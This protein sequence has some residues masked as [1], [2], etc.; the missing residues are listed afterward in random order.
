MLY[1]LVKN[2]RSYRGYDHSRKV[3]KEEL[4]Q[5]VEHARLC[6]STINE[7]PLRYYIAWEEEE[8]AKIQ[9]LTIWARALMDQMTLP[10]EGKEPTGYIIILQ[11][12][13]ISDQMGKFHRDVGI[14]AQ[15]MLLAATEMGLGGCMI[16]SFS[17]AKVKETLDLPDYLVPMLLVAIGKPD[18]NIIIEEIEEGDSVKY[19]RNEEDNHYVP[20]RKLDDI[21]LFSK[22]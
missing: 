10:H 9:D 21:V 7:Q 20:K 6:P 15:T 3:T 1:D 22:E 16:G 17:P 2:S 12:K 8:V 4:M 14:V 5:M 13:R 18:E 19:Y 11:D